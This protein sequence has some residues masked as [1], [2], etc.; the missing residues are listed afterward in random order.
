MRTPPSSLRVVAVLALWLL[1]AWCGGVTARSYHGE[2]VSLSD[3]DILL[4]SHSGVSH[5][6]RGYNGCFRWSVT[7]PSVARV[8]P[9]GSSECSTAALVTSAMEGG[10]RR[11]TVILAEDVKTGQTFPCT[12]VIDEIVKFEILTTR[13]TVHVGDFEIISVQAFDS[14]GNVF[15]TVE[16][17]PFSWTLRPQGVVQVVPFRDA[18]VKASKTQIAVEEAVRGSPW[19][20]G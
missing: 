4:P 3:P 6:L 2:S 12:V 11:S 16:G 8:E 17:L 7:N 5:R 14:E 19:D 9:E 15:S 18:P 13:R 1:L 10:G 20:E